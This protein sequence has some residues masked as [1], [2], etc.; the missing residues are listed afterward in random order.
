M[1][2]KLAVLG[3]GAIGSSIG[4]DLARAAYDVILIDQWPAH[5]DAMKADGLHVTMRG[6]ESHIPV[7]A[8]HLCEM[9]DARQWALHEQLDIVFLT[10][11]AYDAPW[12]AEFIK[13]FLKPDGVLVSVQNSLMDEWI[14]PIVGR[15]RDIGCAFMLSADV[16][17]PGRVNRNTNQIETKFVLG[18]LDGRIT[19]RL[20]EAAQILGHAGQTRI[21]TNIWGAK[22]SKLMFNGMY[23]TFRGAL[24]AT[25]QEM[26]DDPKVMDMVA[27]L[28]VEAAHVAT[29]LGYTLEPILGL[30][31]EDLK[32]LTED[33]FRKFML[34]VFGDT[35][36]KS[37][38]MVQQ[39]I[40]K[41][42]LTETDLIN[43]LIARK[44]QEANVP[45]PANQALNAVMR[46]I[47]E[48][49]LQPGLSNLRL[50]ER[51]MSG[52]PATA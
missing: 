42:R 9:K 22:W 44:G 18:D 41:G 16:F 49:A 8:F 14:A 33:T 3:T 32:Q 37:T 43:G 50:I 36:S 15:Q 12:L 38:S 6:E 5:V 35:D 4:A 45:T 31:S 10:A 11:K 51:H 21:T 30:T 23:A 47:E 7:R 52:T 19:P 2:A 46:Q 13:P 40:A 27:K 29:A 48:G 1:T 39:D 25:K 24:G 20:E 28:A 26:L 17:E 34:K